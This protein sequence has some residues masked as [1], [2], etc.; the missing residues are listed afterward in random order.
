MSDL[1]ISD[2]ILENKQN[3]SKV[4]LSVL[5]LCEKRVKGIPVINHKFNLTKTTVECMYNW[6]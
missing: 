4:V 2:E 5:L 6:V 3:T 1:V